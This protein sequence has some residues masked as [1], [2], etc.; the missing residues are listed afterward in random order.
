MSAKLSTP[1]FTLRLNKPSSKSNWNSSQKSNRDK[2][3]V[4]AKLE[5]LIN[6]L[7]FLNQVDVQLNEN[8][9]ETLENIENCIWH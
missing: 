9:T 1:N 6:I 8:Y 7:D 4:I 5:K 2:E 3:I